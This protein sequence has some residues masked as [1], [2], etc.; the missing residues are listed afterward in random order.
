M[1]LASVVG[2][3]GSRP[4]A[5]IPA[6]P[7][8]A[9]EIA[10]GDLTA[11]PEPLQPPAQGAI[12]VAF[13]ISEGVTMID[14]CG[15]W[16]VFESVRLLEHPHPLFHL[17]TVAET[18][19]T[20]T[21]HGGIRLCPGFTLA[22]APAPKIIVIP[23]QDRPGEALV[24]WIRTASAHTDLTMSVCTG[25]FI[26]AQTGLLRGKA[27]TTHHNSYTELSMQFPDIDLKRGARFVEVGNLAT[28]GGR[29]SG[30]DLALRV[31]ERYFGRDTALDTAYYLEYQGQGWLDMNS[32]QVYRKRLVSTAEHP[33]CPVC[34]MSVDPDSSPVSVYRGSAY[35]FC[36]LR[37]KLE[38]DGAPEKF[39]AAL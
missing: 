7:R 27:A 25:A 11:R 29:Y 15:P 4:A 1:A 3:L 23:G 17:Y 20:V 13:P 39:L 38:F 19:D 35:Y 30:I 12:T 2:A 18:I 22:T 34:E 24:E 37:H 5:A 14:F 26:L 9:D 21:A 36:M 31:V 6:R 16:D 10:R 8:V 33:L 28:A 32:N